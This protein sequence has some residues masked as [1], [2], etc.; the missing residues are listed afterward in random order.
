MNTPIFNVLI[1]TIGRP[2]LQ[3]QLDSLLPQLSEN[4]ILTLVFDGYTAPPTTFDLSKAKCTVDQDVEPEALKFW[5]HGIRNK[6]ASMLR[7]ADFVLHGDDDDIYTE[8]AFDVL[9]KICTDPSKLYIAKIRGYDR[10]ILPRSNLIKIGN[11]GTPCGVIPYELNK[12][13]MWVLKYGGDGMFYKDIAMKALEVEYIDRV[14]Y[15]VR[16]SR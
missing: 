3:R 14:I 13:G 6:Y 8:Y 5:G 16:P 2:T 10:S 12:E 7:Q 15:I 9:R 1:A 11:I 4:D